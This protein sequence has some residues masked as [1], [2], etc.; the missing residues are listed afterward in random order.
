MRVINLI[1]IAAESEVLRIQHMLKRQAMR[2]VFGLVTVLFGLAVLAVIETLV[3]QV[4]CSSMQPVYASLCLACI[5]LV[6]SIAFGLMAM[7]SSPSRTEREALG[8]RRQ[9]IQ[10]ISVSLTLGALIPIAGTLLQ[11]GR[12]T[13]RRQ[14]FSRKRIS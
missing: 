11:S 8:V 7:K 10:G 2:V 12:T 9:A 3:W 6:L 5:N 4:L 13:P 1:K 14:L